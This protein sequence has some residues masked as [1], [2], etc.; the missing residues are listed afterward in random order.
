MLIQFFDGSKLGL[1][2]GC[3]KSLKITVYQNVLDFNSV[4]TLIVW[5]TLYKKIEP[6]VEGGP[7][8]LKKT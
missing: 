4:S 6:F 1:Y 2:T 5:E 7:I 8:L 3:K